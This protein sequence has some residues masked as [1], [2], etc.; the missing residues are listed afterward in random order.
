MASFGMQ[1]EEQSLD[2]VVAA[3]AA[4]QVGAS[5]QWCTIWKP[6]SAIWTF[7]NYDYLGLLDADVTFQ[8][9]YFEQILRRFDAEP[10]LG[11]AGGVVIDVGLPRDRFP[12]NR[13][14]VPGAVQ[15]FR[16]ECFERIGRLDSDSGRR[17]GWNDMCDGSHERISRPVCLPI[18]S[19][20]ISSRGT[21]PKV[22]WSG[23]SGRW[24]FRDYAAGY[25][26]A[27]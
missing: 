21:S 20:T 16:R 1:S 11:L 5:P 19:W 22:A 2:P 4:L 8:S 18:W 17:M 7:R 10:A 3:C 13:I 15:F 9:D 14:D 25:H 12:R 24:A 23:A 6:A 27:V 26:P